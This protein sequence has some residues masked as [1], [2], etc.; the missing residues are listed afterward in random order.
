MIGACKPQ[1]QQSSS[2]R[3]VSGETAELAMD[4]SGEKQESTEEVQIEFVKE[5]G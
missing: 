3:I 1:K 4:T 5:N 2:D